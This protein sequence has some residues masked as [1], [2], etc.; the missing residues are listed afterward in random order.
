MFRAILSIRAIVLEK[1]FTD[2]SSNA[3][4]PVGRKHFATMKPKT[5]YWRRNFL[6]HASLK[7]NVL[8]RFMYRRCYLRVYVTRQL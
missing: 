3:P 8:V 5:G 4:P 6:G 2:I 1:I 7:G